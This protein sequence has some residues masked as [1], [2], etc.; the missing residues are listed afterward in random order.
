MFFMVYNEEPDLTKRGL[1]Q[2]YQSD[3]SKS[4][5]LDPAPKLKV[6]PKTY[7]KKK[8]KNYFHP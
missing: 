6:V 8:K 1:A 2:P 7:L 5:K 4:R 3:S